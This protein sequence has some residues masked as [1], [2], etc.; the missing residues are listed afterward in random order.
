MTDAARGTGRLW[1]AAAAGVALLVAAAF[2]PVTDWLLAF[3]AW[4]RG[5][6]ALGVAVYAL[7]Y[8]V[9]TVLM[10]PGS[11]LTAGW[12]FLYGPLWGTVLPT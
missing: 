5:L 9:A 8:I 7:V 1:G 10:V 3:V 2:L 11:I 12:G 6:G 4:V